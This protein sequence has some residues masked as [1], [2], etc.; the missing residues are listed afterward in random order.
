MYLEYIQCQQQF[1]RQRKRNKK[2]IKEEKINVHDDE[3]VYMC[4]QAIV[5]PQFFLRKKNGTEKKKTKS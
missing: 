1:Y 2:K 3:A 5:K 4:H